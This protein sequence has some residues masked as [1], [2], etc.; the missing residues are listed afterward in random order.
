MRNQFKYVVNSD[1]VFKFRV[2]PTLVLLIAMSSCKK[3]VDVNPPIT[4]I[5][6]ASVY[7]TDANS[8]SAVTGIY[9]GMMNTGIAGGMVSMSLY[10]GLSADEFSVYGSNATYGPFYTNNLNSSVTGNNIFWD[11]IYPMIYT[12]NSVISGVGSS[13]SLTP[14]IKQQLLGETTFMRAFCYFYLTNLYGDVPLVTGTDYTSN[15]RLARTPQAQVFQQ[16]ITDLKTADSL[17]ARNYVDGTLLL[18]T[19]ERV[20]PTKWAAAAL[21]ARAYL[22]TGDW[23]D[24]EIQAD[25]VI[26]NSALYKLGTLSNAFKRDSSE[27][28]W[29]L[30]PVA[31]VGQNTPDALLFILPATGPSVTSFPIYLNNDL[32]NSFEPGDKRRLNWVDSV[33]VGGIKY[34]YAYKYKVNTNTNPVSEY[35]MV[36]RLGEVYLI[37]AEARAQENNLS[38]ASDDLDLIRFRAGLGATTATTKDSLLSAIYHERRVELFSEWGHRW[39]DL[40]RTGMIDAVMDTAAAKKGGTWASY[41]GLYPI[42]ISEITL[43]PNVVQ[44]SG[45]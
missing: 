36:L 26:A 27:A 24:A 1:I 35:E 45:Y 14:A 28:I 37:R 23:A 5:T 38:G 13:N 9:S 34:F 25:S 17:L 39:F 3:L 21:L 44:N 43:D 42:P 22:Y 30:Q 4:S 33:V 31:L 11:V 12:I 41:K 32:V 10:P 20:R 40:R 19:A 8:I 29:Q 16:I 7:T 15:A 6:G 2:L 18:S